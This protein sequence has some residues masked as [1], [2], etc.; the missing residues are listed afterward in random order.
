MADVARAARVS[1]QTVSRVANGSA[2]VTEHTR[3]RVCKAIADLGYRPNAAARALK[4]GTFQ[5]LGVVMFDLFSEGQSRILAAIAEAA[6]EVGYSIVLAPSGPRTSEAV[7]GAVVRLEEMSTDAVILVMEASPCEG[8]FVVPTSDRLV[9]V[10]SGDAGGYP[11]VDTDQA[12]G[13]RLAVE[14]L[15][16]LGHDTVHHVTG[17]VYSYAAKARTQAWRVALEDNGRNVPEPLGGDWSASSGYHAGLSLLRDPAVTAVF[18]A[19][20]E[21]ALGL[22]RAA[23]ELGRDIPGDLSVVGFDDLPIGTG[24]PTPLTTVHQDFHAL[25]R[26]CVRLALRQIEGAATTSDS[27]RIPTSLVVRSSTAPPHI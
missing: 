12:Q 22:T 7:S 23:A 13:A 19:N 11:S 21:E 3:E 18:C 2:A 10:T 25:G 4:R 15:L 20:D 6:S 27:I 1:P 14:H 24:F 8:T 17:P 26:A 16:S 5:S 9:V